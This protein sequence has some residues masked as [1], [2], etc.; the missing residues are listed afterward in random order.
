MDTASTRSRSLKVFLCHSLGDK[1]VV[2]ALYWKLRKDGIKP[3]LDEEDLLPGQKWQH[4]ITK[5][6]RSTDVVLVCISSQSLTK[7]GY[8]QKEIRFALDA[9]DEKP[10]G[11]I[12]LIPVRLADCPLPDRLAQ[13]QWVDLFEENGYEKLLRALRIRARTVSIEKSPIRILF[14]DDDQLPTDYY[15]YALRDRGFD[16]ILCQ[17]ADAAQMLWRE[18]NPGV[19]ILDVMMLPGPFRLDDTNDG[20]HTGLSLY[21]LLRHDLP[22]IPVVVFTNLLT[23]PQI[24]AREI[25][26]LRLRVL[27]KARIPPSEL[28]SIIEGM[29]HEP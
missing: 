22:R 14:I 11:T 26:D 25:E 3:W 12:F 18:L 17:S 15:L 29:L 2:R 20:L 27:H 6:V 21:R 7:E 8:V 23:A 16:V 1:P 10:D 28:V 4:E 19:V 24:F 9:A 5:A 13:W